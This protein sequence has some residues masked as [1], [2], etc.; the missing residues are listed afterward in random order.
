VPLSGAAIAVLVSIKLTREV[1][2]KGFIFPSAR[3][4]EPLSNVAMLYLLQRSD[5]MNRREVTVH[6]F[7]SSFRD[8]AAER[9]SFASEAAEMALAHIVSEQ[10]RGRVQA[11]RPVRE[12]PA[13]C[14]GLGE[15]L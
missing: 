2:P 12:A 7:R 5:R 11:R 14:R 3:A 13:A 10:G 4:Q 1:D 8:W 9:T 15:I 6:G